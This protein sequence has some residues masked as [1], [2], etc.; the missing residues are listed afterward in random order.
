MGGLQSVRAGRSDSRHA[1][2]SCKQ[3][4]VTESTDRFGEWGIFPPSLLL[5]AVGRKKG[6]SGAHGRLDQEGLGG[7]ELFLHTCITQALAG[8]TEELKIEISCSNKVSFLTYSPHNT[9]MHNTLTRCTKPQRTWE[10][11]Q[12]L[13]YHF[14]LRQSN[15]FCLKDT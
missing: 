4:C 8:C 7:G 10:F 11:A 12:W 15:K 9:C 14:C 13:H 6:L 2:A 5:L 3:G 1:D